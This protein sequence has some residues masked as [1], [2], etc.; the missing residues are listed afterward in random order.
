VASRNL[1]LLLAAVL[2]WRLPACCAEPR[3]FGRGFD[4]T[5]YAMSPMTPE[6]IVSQ[7]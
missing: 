1:A 3:T 2:D 7:L 5:V 4:H 6:A